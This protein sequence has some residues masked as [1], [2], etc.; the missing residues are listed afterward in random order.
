MGTAQSS[1]V[2]PLVEPPT[3]IPFGGTLYV[4]GVLPIVG[5]HMSQV[6]CHWWNPCLELSANWWNPRSQGCCSP[7]LSPNLRSRSLVE[8]P[9]PIDHALDQL[10]EPPG[11]LSIDQLVEPPGSLLIDQLVEPPGSLSIDQLVEPPTWSIGGTPNQCVF[12]HICICNL[13]IYLPESW[14]GSRTT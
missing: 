5:R 11:S 8:P 3:K 2:E 10:V 9:S 4:T 13:H 6:R 1:F 7:A 14:P 12:F